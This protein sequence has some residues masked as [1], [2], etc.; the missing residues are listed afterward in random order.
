M[1]GAHLVLVMDAL[2]AAC[3]LDITQMTPDA[4][5]AFSPAAPDTPCDRHAPEFPLTVLLLIN[6]QT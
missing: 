3:A 6:L 4:R 2:C 1:S 5:P